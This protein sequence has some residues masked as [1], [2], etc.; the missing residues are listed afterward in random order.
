MASC[1]NAIKRARFSV[2][3]ALISITGLLAQ[4]QKLYVLTS[5]NGFAEPDI[6]METDG[7]LTSLIE[8]K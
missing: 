8:R 5:S 1:Q 2:C 7:W 3:C 4:A 6:D